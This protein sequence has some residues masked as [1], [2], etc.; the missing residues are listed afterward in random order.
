MS[1]GMLTV[2]L[3]FLI[4]AASGCVAVSSTKHK[5]AAEARPTKPAAQATPAKMETEDEPDEKK[6][7]LDPKVKRARLLRE[8][9]IAKEKV[10]KAGLALEHQQ[11]D[12]QAELTQKDTEHELAITKLEDFEQ[13]D[14]P[15]Q[16]DEAG[17]KLLRAED[18]V[19]DSEEELAQLEMMYAEEDLADKTREIV[20]ERSRRRLERARRDLALKRTALT[21]LEEHSLP[22]E[23]AELRSQMAEKARLLE[24]LRRALEAHRLEKHIE[25]M[26]AQDEVARIG[27]DIRKLDEEAQEA[28][29]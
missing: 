15:Q 29:E 20:L 2:G 5:R 3:M 17:L 22:R 12:D 10:K 25:L 8:L 27:E 18:W 13:H 11:A 26:K 14:A 28:D 4:A 6:D 21:N 23:A 1:K 9:A 7:E 19:K 16:L 24:N